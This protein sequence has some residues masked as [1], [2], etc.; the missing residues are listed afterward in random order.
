[1]GKLISWVIL[2]A[3]VLYLIWGII[4]LVD[5]S[6]FSTN[7]I[8][9][10]EYFFDKTTTSLAFLTAGL[11]ATASFKVKDKFNNFL[12]LLP[13]QILLLLASM[14]GVVS[15]IRGQYIDGVIR[16]SAFIFADQLPIILLSLV[17]GAAIYEKFVRDK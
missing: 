17:Y 7:P 10:F 6:A 12:M 9:F 2:Y 15:T 16:P 8:G 5:S 3:T 14:S 4:L 11:L 1:M 13:Q